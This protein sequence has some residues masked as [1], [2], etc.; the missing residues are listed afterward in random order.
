[1][2]PWLFRELILFLLSLLAPPM[3]WKFSAETGV[4]DGEMLC[5]RLEGI[6]RVGVEFNGTVETVAPEEAWEAGVT[7]LSVDKVDPK[8]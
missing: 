4:G 8:N 7:E 1:M 2:F 3:Y 5:A 6:S